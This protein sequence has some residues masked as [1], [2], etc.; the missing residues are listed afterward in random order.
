MKITLSV[1]V[2]FLSAGAA[3]ADQIT[4]KDGDRITGAIVKKDGDSITVK[5]KNFGT[6][7]LKWAD[8]ATVKSDEPLNITLPG[9]KTVRANIETLGDRIQVAA[10]EAPQAVDPKDVVTLRDDA[11]ERTYQKYLHPGLLDL[12]TITGG[13]NLAGTAGNAETS[14][15]TTPLNFVRASNTTR[16]SAY[17]NSITSSATVD[18]VN[19]K[20]A[21]AIRGGWGYNRKIDSS[22]LFFN[23]FNDYEYDKFQS[24]DLRVTLGGGV[25]Y[26]IWTH[27]ASRLSATFGGDWDRAAFGASGRSAAFTRSTGEFFWGDDFNYKVSARTSFVETFRMF[28]NL[29]NT[30]EY[31]MNADVS[32]T[33]QLTRWL[34]WNVSLSDRYLSDPAPGF[35]KNDFLYS[36]GLGFSWA[37]K[38]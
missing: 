15:L 28:D 37:R 7:T 27:D 19:S 36:T 11:E 14:T 34:N 5:S 25:G 24:L 22:K 21:K 23:G 31:R 32:A 29:S 33:T 35:K 2:L 20:T 17:F 30:G 3:M 6:V 38:N 9:G 8:I 13:L 16:T 12:W 10:P 1:C 4:M 26:S 18:G